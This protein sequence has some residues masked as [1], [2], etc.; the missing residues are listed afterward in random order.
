MMLTIVLGKKEKLVVDATIIEVAISSR[1]KTKKIKRI[2][3]KRY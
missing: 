3:G 1:A 2:S